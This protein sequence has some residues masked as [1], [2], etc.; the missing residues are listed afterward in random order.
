[1]HRITVARFWKQANKLTDDG[2]D[3]MDVNLLESN[4]GQT[5][6]I[7][8]NKMS[9]VTLCKRG[10]IRLTASALSIPNST[11]YRNIQRS[12]I[13]R[14]RNAVKPTLTLTNMVEGEVFCKVNTKDEKTTFCYM[15]NVIHI[16]KKW[17]YLTKNCRKYYFGVQESESIEPYVEKYIS[18][19]LCFVLLLTVLVGILQ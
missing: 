2:S 9:R 7:G 1:M 3:F 12:E 18:Q 8:I 17:F 11:L 19:K 10:T 5:M 6:E 4:C 15:M 16:D 13:K 14:H